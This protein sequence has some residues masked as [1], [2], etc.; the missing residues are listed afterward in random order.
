MVAADC[1][2]LFGAMASGT[3]WLTHILYMTTDCHYIVVQLSHFQQHH[4]VMILKVGHPG[5]TCEQPI[6][7]ARYDNNMVAFQRVG[8]SS[9]WLDLNSV[10]IRHFP[11]HTVKPVI[12]KFQNS[13]MLLPQERYV[14]SEIFTGWMLKATSC[15]RNWP[16]ALI[17][18]RE[19]SP[20]VSRCARRG[21]AEGV[22]RTDNQRC[23][24]WWRGNVP[25][26]TVQSGDGHISVL[27]GA[28]RD[29]WRMH[30]GI[31]K[32]GLLLLLFDRSVQ[33]FLRYLQYIYLYDDMALV[34]VFCP[35]KVKMMYQ[36]HDVLMETVKMHCQKMYMMWN[37]VLWKKCIGWLWSSAGSQ[38]IWCLWISS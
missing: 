7:C 8:G 32:T 18:S 25:R 34:T 19:M 9:G 27:S 12:I 13:N 10:Q 37:K 3:T 5:I 35:D 22:I 14:L 20:S 11:N 16:Y 1:L 24:R 38:K 15:G 33:I 6:S 28:L 30:C 2:T 26:Y 29:A 31:C 23:P 4:N 21:L 36:Q 17:F